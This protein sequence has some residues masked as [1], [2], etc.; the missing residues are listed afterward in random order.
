MYINIYVYGWG[1]LV[2]D[3]NESDAKIRQRIV[4]VV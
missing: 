4:L 3:I 1:K 2:R